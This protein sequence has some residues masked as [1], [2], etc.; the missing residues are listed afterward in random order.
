MIAESETGNAEAGSKYF[1]SREGVKMSKEGYQS[2]ICSCRNPSVQ[3]VPCDAF[4]HV[5]T[6]KW[7]NSLSSSLISM[8]T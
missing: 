7:A 8:L 6:H 2:Q 3:S 4:Q 5:H 1:E